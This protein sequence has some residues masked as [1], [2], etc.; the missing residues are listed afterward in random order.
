MFLRQKDG[1]AASC[2]G[3]CDWGFRWDGVG[4]CQ[5]SGP[6]HPIHGS[7]PE[8]NGLAGSTEG[9]YSKR[10][11]SPRSC[12]IEGLTQAAEQVAGS[13][14]LR[15]Q[16]G[17]R[18]CRRGP[19]AALLR[20]NVSSP[21][22]SAGLPVNGPLPAGGARSPQLPSPLLQVSLSNGLTLSPE[23][24]PVCPPTLMAPQSSPQEPTRFSL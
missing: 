22:P 21:S 2:R 3:A 13:C 17:L 5:A 12:S 10:P 24:K 15:R 20:E 4:M 18:G 6:P 14:S 16:N 1:T 9:L 23:R 8:A 11:G 19:D 7:S